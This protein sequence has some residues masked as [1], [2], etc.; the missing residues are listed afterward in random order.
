MIAFINWL[1]KPN[2]KV[3][4]KGTSQDNYKRYNRLISK[5]VKDKIVAKTS[6]QKS[7]LKGMIQAKYPLPDTR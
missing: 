1:I 5:L 7:I 6:C 2:R 4:V 3:G